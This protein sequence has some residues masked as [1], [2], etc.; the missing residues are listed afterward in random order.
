MNVKETRPV[1]QSNKRKNII[2]NQSF[3]VFISPS[4]SQRI[5]IN[6][7]HIVTNL[8]APQKQQKLAT[9]S[10]YFPISNAGDYS[11]QA[12]IDVN[13]HCNQTRYSLKF[14]LHW[15]RRIFI[16]LLRY[17]NCRN[18]NILNWLIT[19]TNMALGLSQTMILSFHQFKRPM[20]IFN[21][22]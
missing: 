16:V 3:V 11:A 7:S 18:I 6:I 2:S 15:P 8:Y 22:L 5:P 20:T 14:T 4:Y 10:N 17:W 12:T 19:N 13:C 21:C 1:E 9:C